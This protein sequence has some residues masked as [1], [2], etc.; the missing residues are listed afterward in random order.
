M[1]VLEKIG[2]SKTQLPAGHEAGKPAL[3]VVHEDLK[4]TLLRC[5]NPEDYDDPKGYVH[6][7][8]PQELCNGCNQYN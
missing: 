4:P 6:H 8:G 3:P 5:R 2:M 7:V 1:S